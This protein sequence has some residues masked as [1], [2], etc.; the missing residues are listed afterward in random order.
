[1]IPGKT[2]AELVASGGVHQGAD[3]V[4]ALLAGAQAVQVCSALYQ[5]GLEHLGQLRSSLEQWMDS[6]S[7]ASIDQFRGKMSQKRSDRPETFE[8]LQY[9][10]ALVGQS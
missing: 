4:K 8:R 7:Y 5:N 9:I 3:A 1:M 10:K 2:Q 6:H